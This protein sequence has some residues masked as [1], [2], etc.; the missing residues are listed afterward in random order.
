MLDYNNLNEVQI[1]LLKKRIIDLKGDVN[2][3]MA[4]YVREALFRLKTENDPD[5]EVQISSNGGDVAVGLCIYDMLKNYPGQKTGI[6]NGFARSMGA[7][8][9]QACNVRCCMR[10]SSVLIHHVSINRISLD[11][12]RSKKKLKKRKKDME[13]DQDS[14]YKILMKKTGKSKEEIMAACRKDLGM[15]SKEAKE[16]G[17]IDKII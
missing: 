2:D 7:I 17:L 9:L 14:L 8:I 16:F 13:K 15:T 12:L 4:Y 3:E 1:A 5:I 11:E 6:V 10:H